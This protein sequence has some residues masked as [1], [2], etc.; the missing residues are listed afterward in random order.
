MAVHECSYW[1]METGDWLPDAEGGTLLLAPPNDSA[2]L[3]IDTVGAWAPGWNGLLI[4]A[5]KRAP[6]G[7]AIET[8]TCGAFSG[9]KYEGRDAEGAYFREWLLALGEC[10]LLVSYSTA[11]QHRDRD[12]ALVD[13]LLSTLADRRA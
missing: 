9:L 7:A 6:S 5:R 3:R 11:A 13:F 1:S 10:F 2:L 4:E 8:V 12:F